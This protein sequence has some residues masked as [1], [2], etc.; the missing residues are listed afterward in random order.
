MTPYVCAIAI[1]SRPSLSAQRIVCYGKYIDKQQNLRSAYEDVQAV[2]VLIYPKY[3]DR[4]TWTNSVD[5]D[6]MPRS[7]ASDQGLQ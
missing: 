3:W 5:P 4:P 2:T 1:G 7:V 6:Q